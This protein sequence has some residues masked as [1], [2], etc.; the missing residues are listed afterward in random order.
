MGWSI[1]MLAGFVAAIVGA[2][3]IWGYL[4]QPAVQKTSV[5]FSA[6]PIHVCGSGDHHRN[7]TT[8]LV[9]G[10]TGWEKG[11]KWRLRDVDTPEISAP[12]C[13]DEL[14]KGL[15]ARDRLQGLMHGGYRIDTSGATDR[16]GRQL[17]S[18]TLPNG[19][20]AARVLLGEGH[21]QPGPKAQRDWCRS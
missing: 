19:T 17:V 12:R 11:V 9:D 16:Y 10:D 14:R 4:P 15:A 5:G 8:C 6:G 20:D 7:H 21:A 2:F 1:A 3:H 13:A 18:M